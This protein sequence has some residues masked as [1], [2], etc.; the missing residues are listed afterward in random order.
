MDRQSVRLVLGMEEGH[1]WN[2]TS[3]S[4]SQNLLPACVG[5]GHPVA[6]TSAMVNWEEVLQGQQIGGIQ[7][8]KTILH[9]TLLVMCARK[10]DQLRELL[11][12]IHAQL[13]C[14]HNL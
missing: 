14:S 12:R 13:G 5:W 7:S 11:E 6:Q 3:V 1:R 4:C 8:M 10:F 2:P 9:N